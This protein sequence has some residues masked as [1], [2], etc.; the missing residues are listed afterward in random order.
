MREITVTLTCSDELY[1]EIEKEADRLG[2]TPEEVY[3]FLLFVGSERH[4]KEGLPF[5]R[6]MGGKS[7][8][9]A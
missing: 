3:R 8:A 2:E 9:E 7:H 4:I 5:L 6:Q 1:A